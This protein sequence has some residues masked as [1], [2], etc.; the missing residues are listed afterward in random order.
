MKLDREQFLAAA[1]AMS[2]AMGGCKLGSTVDDL[3]AQAAPENAPATPAAGN[4][5]PSPQ[6]GA[7]G[8]PVVGREDNRGQGDF[9]SP[10]SSDPTPTSARG[11]N[12]GTTS[13]LVAGSKGST[14]AS[15]TKEA[16]PSP[17]K[18][19]LPSPTKEALPSPTKEA[20]P[21]PTKETKYVAPTKE[22]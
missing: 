22:K 11:T 3:A 6:P 2:A 4:A 7:P 20:L 18:E 19:A 1:I 8:S 16:L 5:A 12:T 21:S 17:T 13:G 10:G 14:L 15:P 9:G